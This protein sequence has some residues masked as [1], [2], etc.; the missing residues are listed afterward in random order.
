MLFRSIMSRIFKTK[1]KPQ[2][3]LD[4]GLYPAYIATVGDTDSGLPKIQGF[5]TT[6]WGSRIDT[7]ITKH[8]N[9]NSYMKAPTNISSMLGIDDVDGFSDNYKTIDVRRSLRL[10]SDV[11]RVKLQNQIVNKYDINALE[12]LNANYFEYNYIQLMS[13]QTGVRGR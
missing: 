12:Y 10:L 6:M 11:D 2:N 4:I 8:Q 7:F 5:N 3:T 13:L 9:Y 1:F